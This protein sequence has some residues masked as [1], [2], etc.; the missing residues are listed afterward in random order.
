MSGCVPS[1]LALL[2]RRSTWTLILVLRICEFANSRHLEAD[3]ETNHLLCIAG[4]SPLSHLNTLVLLET[5]ASSIPIH[6]PL[7]DTRTA[8]LGP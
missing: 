4:S 2:V 8:E 7:F 6:P 5:G 1:R 3:I